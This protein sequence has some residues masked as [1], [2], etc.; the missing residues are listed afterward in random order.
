MHIYSRIKIK[1]WAI[2]ILIHP[3]VINFCHDVH[4]NLPVSFCILQFNWLVLNAI[5]NL[6]GQFYDVSSHALEYLISL[7]A[8]SFIVGANWSELKGKHLMQ[9]L[10]A[11]K[12]ISFTT[13]LKIPI[14]PL[15]PSP[16]SCFVYNLQYFMCL[17]FHE[18]VI[19]SVY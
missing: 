19:F 5:H 4:C 8:S 10:F 13:R 1:F 9:E 3:Y 16:N 11:Q 6:L 18:K 12:L 17:V 2:L 15:A 7:T 14:S